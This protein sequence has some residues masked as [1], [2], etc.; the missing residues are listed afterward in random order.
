[1]EDGG[2]AVITGTAT[3]NGKAGYT[4]TVIVQDLKE[5]GAGKDTFRIQIT[6]PSGALSY[7]S[8]EGVLTA[9]NVQVHK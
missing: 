6:G 9:G 2:R 7:D 3:V 8:L 4:Y 5:P 1:M